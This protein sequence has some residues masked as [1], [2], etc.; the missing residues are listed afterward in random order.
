MIEEKANLIHGLNDKLKQTSEHANKVLEMKEM[1]KKEAELNYKMIM[2]E[3]Q[4]EFE[5]KL[6]NMKE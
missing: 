2:S 1:G 5:R 3:K 6:R 4:E